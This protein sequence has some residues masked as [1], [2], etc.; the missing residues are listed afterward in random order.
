MIGVGLP[1]VSH[2]H[3]VQTS[4]VSGERTRFGFY[5]DHFGAAA[6][7]CEPQVKVT[8]GTIENAEFQQQ[9]W[10]LFAATPGTGMVFSFETL[11]GVYSFLST[12]AVR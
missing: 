11:G 1:L 9:T 5:H 6:R 3:Q 2:R 12:Q 8:I 7:N 4:A 10:L